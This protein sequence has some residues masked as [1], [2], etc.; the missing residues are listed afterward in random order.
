MIAASRAVYGVRPVKEQIFEGF[1]KNSR[2]Q[3]VGLIQQFKGKW[4]AHIRIA[5][6]ARESDEVIPTRK[7]VAI[8]VSRFKELR[9]GVHE[10]GK[11]ASR[12]CVVAQIEQSKRTEI[13]VGVNE[14]KGEV[15]CYVRTFYRDLEKDEWQP[16]KGLSVRVEQLKDLE[17]LVD[18]IATALDSA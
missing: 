17:D 11:V 15:L 1:E 8:D 3:V 9:D 7:G 14:Y 12:D 13:R 18:E 6:L 16:G 10:L 2:E 5:V 4:L